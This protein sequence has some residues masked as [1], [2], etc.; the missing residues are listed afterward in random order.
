MRRA[1]NLWEVDRRAE[2]ETI[3]ARMES[4]P[5]LTVARL[6][7]TFHGCSYLIERWNYLGRKM[8]SPKFTGEFD[9][10]D[11]AKALNLMG[12]P[13]D[14]HDL[15]GYSIDTPAI[16][17]N[18]PTWRKDATMEL[19]A[20]IGREF[21]ELSDLLDD[22]RIDDE[23]LREQAQVGD[24][25]GT[26]RLLNRYERAMQACERRIRSLERSAVK[27]EKAPPEQPEASEP[28]ATAESCS[29]TSNEPSES[30][31]DQSVDMNE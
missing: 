15:D 11:R 12:I 13:R 20:V 24:F 18:S 10:S 31:Y 17:R 6:K 30:T 27:A 25:H 26:D 14:E 28:E 29:Q 19:S 5:G 3:A 1:V 2:V 21:E 23:D 22:L 16:G 7:K 9:A 4:R 8:I